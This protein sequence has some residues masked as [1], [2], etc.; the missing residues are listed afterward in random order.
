MTPTVYEW[1]GG[2][3]ALSR[4]FRLFYERVHADAELGPIFAGAPPEHPEHV[5]AFVGDVL[6]GPPVYGETL[7]GHPT[8]I[9]RHLGKALGE[10][11]RRRW[12][13]MLLDCADEA[14]IPDD[15]EVRSALVGYL[16]W[17]SRLAVI[18]SQPGADVDAEQPMPRW[19]WGETKGPYRGNR[20]VRTPDKAEQGTGNG[21]RATGNN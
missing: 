8:M 11:Q 2:A 10:A 13:S 14:G 4:W 1:I 17:G 3:P 21:Q 12:L 15:P 19:G 20:L 18:N 6:G 5:A 7:G 9:R 16:E